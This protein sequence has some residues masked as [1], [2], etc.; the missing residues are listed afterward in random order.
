MKLRRV[1]KPVLAIAVIAWVAFG[2]FA[3]AKALMDSGTSSADPAEPGQQAPQGPPLPEHVAIGAEPTKPR[4]EGELLSIYLGPD[5]AKAP[6][7]AV[8]RNEQLNAEA[9]DCLDKL[10]YQPV[11]TAQRFALDFTPPP[12]F[13]L[14]PLSV[15]SSGPV[16]SAV[17][18]CSESGVELGVS[19]NYA[20]KFNHT[21]R[22]GEP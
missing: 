12:G 16:T 2:S 18:V 10:V 15:S 6:P 21:R 8:E 20:T 4:F 14:A 5:L 1:W 22:P 7:G 9:T 19:W 11:E 13:V 3:A 17:A